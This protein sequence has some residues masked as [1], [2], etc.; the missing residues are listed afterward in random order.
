MSKEDTQFSGDKQPDSDKKTGPRFRTVLFDTLHKAG[1]FKE[2]KKKKGERVKSTD[3]EQEFLIHVAA[4]AF[5]KDDPASGAIL[6]EL[7]RKS[8]P[9]AKPVLS[10]VAIDVN[11]SLKPH[12]QAQQI[13]QAACDGELPPDVGALFIQSLDSIA[14]IQQKHE[15]A[16]RVERL[17]QMMNAGAN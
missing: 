7:L 17:E 6:K 15:L 12:Q 16:E 4:R 9:T 14:T 5:D 3:I 1:V 8:Y 11:P 2:L 13:L 10:T